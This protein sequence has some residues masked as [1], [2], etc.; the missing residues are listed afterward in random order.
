MGGGGEIIDLKAFYTDANSLLPDVGGAKVMNILTGNNDKRIGGSN[1][2]EDHPARWE[3]GGK[4]GWGGW[5]IRR[6]WL[7]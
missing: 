6:R 7:L 2:T 4:Q 5:G 1:L 3:V